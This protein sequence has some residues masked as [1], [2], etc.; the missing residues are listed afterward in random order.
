[1]VSYLTLAIKR[2]Y[3]NSTVKAVARAAVLSFVLMS[4]IL[5]YHDLLFFTAFYATK[6]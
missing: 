4:L 1:M 2:A 3:G 5:V 6:S